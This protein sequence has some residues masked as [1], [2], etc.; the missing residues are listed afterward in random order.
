[1]STTR[2][3]FLVAQKLSLLRYLRYLRYRRYRTV[4]RYRGYTYLRYL[5][6]YFSDISFGMC[7]NLVS[8]V[9]Q[10][11]NAAVVARS[12]GYQCDTDS[13]IPIK[14]EFKKTH[15]KSKNST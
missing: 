12:L 8:W 5:R 11:H 13:E 7:L 4:G 14:L 9:Q 1:M 15:L 6:T 3:D 2:A 10:V